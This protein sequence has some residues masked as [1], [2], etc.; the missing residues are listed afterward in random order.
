[1]LLLPSFSGRGRRLVA[2]V[3]EFAWNNGCARIEITSGDHRP[4]AQAFYEATGYFQD[5]RRF[6]KGPASLGSQECPLMLRP[7]EGSTEVL[8]RL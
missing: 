2:E 8:S 7:R 5:C 6:H 3:E 4:D 1:M